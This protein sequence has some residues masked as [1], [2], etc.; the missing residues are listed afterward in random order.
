MR[1]VGG[2]VERRTSLKT[3]AIASAKVTQEH[4]GDEQDD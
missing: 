3:Y 2:A 4:D 1:W